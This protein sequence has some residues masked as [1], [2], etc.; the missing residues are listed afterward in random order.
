MS[1]QTQL[2][3][4]TSD[5]NLLD[6]Q[7]QWVPVLLPFDAIYALRTKINRNSK[8]TE[9]YAVVKNQDGSYKEKLVSRDWLDIN[10]DKEF[11]EK[12]DK[13]ENESGW[14]MFAEEDAN[15]KIIKDE[16]DV[17][18]V[19]SSNNCAPIYTYRPEY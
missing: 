7:K 5:V 1:L 14:V 6:W 17:R 9:Y 18:N 11:L 19:L 3:E 16:S 12:F 15:M 10:V 4:L 8:K 2:Q 13:A